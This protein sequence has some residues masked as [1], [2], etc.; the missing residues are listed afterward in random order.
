VVLI[1]DIIDSGGTIIKASDMMME[2]GANS[3]RAVC[4]HAVFSGNAKEKLQNS[5]LKEI[6]VSD[7]Y[8]AKSGG[9]ITVLSTA[10]IFADVIDKIHNYES[11][12][13]HFQFTTIL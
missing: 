3:V 1:D 11:I 7:T 13:E 9:N 8:P 10:S 4:T 12:S 2:Q 5:S 6:I